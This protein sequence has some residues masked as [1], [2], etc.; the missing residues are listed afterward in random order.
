MEQLEVAV[1]YGVR[2][3]S[4]DWAVP[5]VPVTEFD[6]H[7][8]AIDYLKA[9]LLAW[10]ARSNRAVKVA[11]NLGIRWVESEPR[12][13]FDPDLC[14]IEPAPPADEPLTSLRLWQPGHAAPLLAVEVVSPGHPYKNYVDTP[15][16]CAACG[17]G[18]LWVYDPMLAG[19][20]ARGGP[21]LL[22]VWQRGSGGELQRIHA[23]PGPVR[24][25]ALGAW[26]HPRASRLPAGATLIVSADAAGHERWPTCEEQA[27][28]S[29]QQARRSEQ[30]A[31]SLLDQVQ[32]ERD[33]L[34]QRVRE[35]EA[36]LT[37]RE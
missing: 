30:Q 20:A 22:Q 21:M 7:D 13:G 16:R 26:L 24:S 33:G 6:T 25:P 2:R 29:E 37:P 14:V 31:R 8:A 28:R 27:R 34:E 11:R 17:V 4:P 32:A 23:G 5:E 19:P 1:R 15:D 35:L 12:V 10:A 3:W 9:L 36:R 18:E